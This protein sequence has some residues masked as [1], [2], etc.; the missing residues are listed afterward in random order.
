MR[1][2]KKYVALWLI[3]AF[4]FGLAPVLSAEDT[5]KININQ[6][7][8]EELTQLERIGPSYAQRI[9]EYRAKNGPFAKPED[10]MKVPGVGARAF[11]ANKDRICV[12]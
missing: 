1:H 5:Q 7:P 12:E 6:A 2:V 10:I 11:E 8:L 9:V 3:M 4:V